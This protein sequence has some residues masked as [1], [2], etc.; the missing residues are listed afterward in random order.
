MQCHLETTS[1]RLPHSIL[2]FDR[3]AF[4]YK[5]GQPLSEYV[6]HF[7]HAPGTGWDDKFEIAHQAY[8]LRKSACFQKSAGKLTCT[9][10]HDPHN[11]PRGDAAVQRFTGV[12]RGCHA[13]QLERLVSAK[14]HTAEP[15]CLECHMPKRRTE[16]VAHVIM[17]DHYIQRRKPSRDLLAPLAERHETEET[18]YRGPAVPYYPARLSS[19]D[20]LYL[21]V[22]QVKQAN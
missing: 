13:Q 21:A 7:D 4:S 15:N 2:R 9:T 11:A 3:G 16:D 6:L 1:T 22:A 20:E 10:C 14:R 19:Q 18:L 8:R 5:P 17:T 12:C